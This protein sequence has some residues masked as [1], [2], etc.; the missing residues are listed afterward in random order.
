MQP[1]WLDSSWV[2]PMRVDAEDIVGGGVVGGWAFFLP[3]GLISSIGPLL[4]GPSCCPPA[5][6]LSSS[7]H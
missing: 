7:N 6:P 4:H 5:P 3:T 1:C 2:W